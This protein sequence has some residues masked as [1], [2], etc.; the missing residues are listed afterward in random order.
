MGQPHEW[1]RAITAKLGPLSSFLSHAQTHAHSHP[2]TI[3]CCSLQ[4]LTRCQ[5]HV[6]GFLSL[7]NHEPNKFYCLFL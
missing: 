2:Y 1:I 5:C 6:L 7:Q 3:L 4:A